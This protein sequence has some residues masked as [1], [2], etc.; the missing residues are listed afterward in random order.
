MNY[1]DK[2][3]REIVQECEASGLTVADYCRKTGLSA[4]SIYK[5]RVEFG[6]HEESNNKPFIELGADNYY[7]IRRADVVL[8]IPV[9]ESAEKISAILMSC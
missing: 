6:G 3:K 8:R 2:R 5:W 7:E 9:S 1:S 4:K